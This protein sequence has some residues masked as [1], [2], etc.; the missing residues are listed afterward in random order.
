VKNAI[1]FL[2]ISLLLVGMLYAPTAYAN[3]VTGNGGEQD[4]DKKCKNNKYN[5]E[6]DF[7]KPGV[8]INSPDSHDT[9][10]GPIVLIKGH[11]FDNGGGIH[12]SIK[13]VE[14]SV[15]GGPFAL[16]SSGNGPWSISLFLTGGHHHILAKATDW[17]NN[18][19]RAHVEIKVIALV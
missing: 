9:V 3:A 10:T 18:I 7:A 12:D 16:V 2:S 5:G 4:K 19:A 1:V 6:C 11:A 8:D 13:K 15:D 14:V 17:A